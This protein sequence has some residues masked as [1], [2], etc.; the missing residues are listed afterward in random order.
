MTICLSELTPL[1]TA[2]LSRPDIVAAT[3][4]YLYNRT[5]ELDGRLIFSRLDGKD[6]RFGKD[7]FG[8][9]FSEK[10]AGLK[11]EELRTSVETHAAKLFEIDAVSL[12]ALGRSFRTCTTSNTRLVWIT[13]DRRPVT[14]DEPAG[15]G[16]TMARQ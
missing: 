5:E 12:R 16:A 7:A 11:V 6:S 13:S 4:S 8:R 1:G 9:H 3:L 10:V 15:S 2:G 14:L